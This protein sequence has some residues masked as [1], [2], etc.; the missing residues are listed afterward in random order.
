MRSGAGAF[1]P[2]SRRLECLLDFFTRDLLPGEAA[3]LAELAVALSL[4][5]GHVAAHAV[6]AVR[7]SAKPA[8]IGVRSFIQPRL[9]ISRTPRFDNRTTACFPLVPRRAGTPSWCG[10]HRHAAGS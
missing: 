1:C 6:P 4:A 3:G 10:R 2:R 9:S 5:P 7:S 8:V